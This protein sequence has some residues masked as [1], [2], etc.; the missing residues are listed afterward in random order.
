[1]IAAL[2]QPTSSS[3]TALWSAVMKRAVPGSES[4]AVF[5]AMSAARHGLR[6]S[7]SV[8]I[9]GPCNLASAALGLVGG[10]MGLSA[11][12]ELSLPIVCQ[13]PRSGNGFLYTLACAV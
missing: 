8:S 10:I 13:R 6:I 2:R 11:F 4:I 3:V 12:A 1:M 9:T 5:G 7:R